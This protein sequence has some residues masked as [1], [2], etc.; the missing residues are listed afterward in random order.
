MKL[1][2][3]LLVED[4]DEDAEFLRRFFQIERICNHITWVKA[5]SDA[6]LM[7]KSGTRFDL[8][9]V[10]IRIPGNGGL[11]FV[12]WSAPFPADDVP[13]IV[14]SGMEFE[15]LVSRKLCSSVL[16]TLLGL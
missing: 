2:S 15:A 13:V 5:L 6:K 4:C 1:A 10:D 7:C 16:A 8:L 12:E 3:I 9:I 14:S 11:E